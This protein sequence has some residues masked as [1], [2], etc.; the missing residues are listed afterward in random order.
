MFPLGILGKPFAIAM[1]RLQCKSGKVED[2]GR[3]EGC[4][5][6]LLVTYLEDHPS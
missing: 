6:L 2:G 5:L 3:V 4:S 1:L